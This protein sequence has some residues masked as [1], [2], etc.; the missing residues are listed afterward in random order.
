MLG[1][2]ES[3]TERDLA[4]MFDGHSKIMDAHIPLD[5]LTTPVFLDQLGLLN[6]KDKPRDDEEYIN[7]EIRNPVYDMHVELE[8]AIKA[9]LKKAVPQFQ[10]LYER[11]V[12]IREFKARMVT[13]PDEEEYDIDKLVNA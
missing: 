9:E 10:A 3:W 6:P 4:E 5:P 8:T 13:K 12:A 7:N 11:W 2:D 1:I